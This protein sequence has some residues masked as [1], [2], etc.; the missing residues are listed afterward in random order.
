MIGAIPHP[1]MTAVSSSKER[2]R[3][4][5]FAVEAAR[6]LHDRHCTDVRVIDV[7]AVSQVCD[8]LV[9]ASGTSERQ[10]KSVA[11]ELED[12]GAE[13]GHEVFRSN[14]DSTGTWIVIDFIDLVV[15]L[16]EPEQR[17]YY[18]LEALWSDGGAIEWERDGDE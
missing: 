1:G 10:M 14:R 4:R 17:E 6:L 7:H 3:L 8:Y 9:I 11:S 12:L 2:Q 18:D 15:H 13:Q 16:F 5:T